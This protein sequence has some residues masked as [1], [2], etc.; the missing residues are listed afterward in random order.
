MPIKGLVA[1]LLLG[2]GLWLSAG[3]A[4]AQDSDPGEGEE[5]GRLAA[6]IAACRMVQDP[7]ERLRC[8]D[9]AAGAADDESVV[10]EGVVLQLAGEDDFDSD[11]FVSES[12]WHLRWNSRGSIFT[13]ELQDIAGELIAI[14]GNQIGA[15]ENRSEVQPPGEYRVAVRAIG[16]WQLWVMEED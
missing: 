6:E 2:G 3:Q 5:A 12:P 16:S 13:V 10:A 4:S 8:Y 14:I 9:A 7:T 11:N 15:G 1:A